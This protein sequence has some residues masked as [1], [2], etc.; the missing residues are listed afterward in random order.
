MEIPFWNHTK[1]A[2]VFQVSQADFKAARMF[3]IECE[4][5]DRSMPNFPTRHH[6]VAVL[7]EDPPAE[8]FP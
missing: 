8:M 6:T 2:T 3:S 7:R 4:M 1:E 5:Y